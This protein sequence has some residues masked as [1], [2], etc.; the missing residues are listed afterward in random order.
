LLRSKAFFRQ[1]SDR[2]LLNDR[3]LNDLDDSRLREHRVKRQQRGI[4]ADLPMQQPAAIASG[5]RS[6]VALI[7]L[8]LFALLAFSGFV[9][10]G[11]WQWQRRAW[12]LALI[13]RV[14]TRIHAAPVPVPGRDAWMQISPEDEYRK[15]RLE[16]VFLEDRDTLVSASTELGNGYWVMTPLRT[17][18]GSVVLINRGFVPPGNCTRHSPCPAPSGK[19]TVTGLLRIA[20]TY[21]FLRNNDSARERWYSRD[22]NAIASARGLANVAPYFVDEDAARNS[23]SPN[24]SRGPRGG[25]TT[26]VF[27]NNHLAYML[28]WYGLAGMVLLGAGTVA[29]EQTRARRITSVALDRA[30]H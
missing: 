13:E 23:A 3:R 15:V 21:A 24:E 9:A 30:K 27:A 16:G 2:H 20:Q 29:R 17:D 26:V 1:R 8:A 12:K 19:I 11:N 6:N 25:L 7:A 14:D 5:M 18:D 28:T 4:P 22:V 10:L